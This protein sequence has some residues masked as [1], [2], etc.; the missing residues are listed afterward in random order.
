[1]PADTEKLYE[2]KGRVLEWIED[3]NRAGKSAFDG[4]AARVAVWN[5]DV[6]MRARKERKKEEGGG[7]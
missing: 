7:G 1:L 2:T 6:L 4:D 5:K 3:V